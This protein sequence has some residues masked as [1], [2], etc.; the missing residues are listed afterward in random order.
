MHGLYILYKIS[1]LN[2]RRSGKNSLHSATEQI[3][4]LEA[5]VKSAI[6]KGE[7]RNV[8]P[9][10]AVRVYLGAIDEVIEPEF[11]EDKT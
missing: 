10:L 7:F 9:T 5:L 4:A 11:L 2:C 6:R 1:K 3:L 8:N